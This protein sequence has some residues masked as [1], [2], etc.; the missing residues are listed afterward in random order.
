MSRERFFDQVA[1]SEDPL[2]LTDADRAKV[3]QLKRRLG[4]L[5]GLRVLEPG[6]GV[7]PLTEHLSKWVGPEGRILAFD[8]SR[9]MV[10]QCRARLA[11]LANLEIL[12]A[13][14]ETVDLA[15]AA[16]DLVILFR[17]FPHFDDK[18]ALRRRLRPCLALGGRLVVANLEGSARLNA[19]HAGFS[20]PVRH[21]RMPCARGVRKLFEESGY[22][23]SA[24]LDEPEGFYAEARPL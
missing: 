12:H 16:W 11:H 22:V 7:G 17:V 20:E 19:L 18:A 4:D 6:C 2:L 23:V 21:D 3:E 13:G 9:A 5:A 10:E 14:A 24:V 15:S 1:I 8:A